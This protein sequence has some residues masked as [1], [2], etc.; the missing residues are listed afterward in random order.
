MKTGMGLTLIGIGL[1]LT[2]AVTTNT[3]VFNLHTAGVVF[4][5]IG[6]LGLAIPRRSYS[7][8]GRRMVVRRTR[9]WPGGGR[10]IEETAYPPYYRR[11]DDGSGPLGLG[12]L[13]VVNGGI[14]PEPEVTTVRTEPA[15]VTTPMDPGGGA[16]T[17]RVTETTERV[18]KDTGPAN[19]D[20]IEDIYDE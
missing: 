11:E 2:F 3:S 18:T 20:V 16:R 6:I 10:R 5:F 9:R 17:Q 19:A 7:W 15:D 1:I 14:P 13:S 4:M 12:R 8:L